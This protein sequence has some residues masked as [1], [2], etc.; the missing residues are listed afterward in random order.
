M[1]RATSFLGIVLA[2]LMTSAWMGCEPGR[3]STE[4]GSIGGTILGMD[5]G[6]IVVLRSFDKGNLVN[7][8]Q[9]ALDSAGHFIL[10]PESPLPRGYH[11]LLVGRKYPL[12]LITDASEGVTV[13]ATVNGTGNYL[14]QADIMGSP[15]SKVIQDYYD[16]T[17]PLQARLKDIE[18]MARMAKGEDQVAAKESAKSKMDSLAILSLDFAQAHKNTLAALCALEGLDAVEHK[19]LFQET[20]TALEGQY[21]ESFYFKKIK[22]SFNRANLPRTLDLPN[23][24]AKKRTGK[25]SKYGQGDEAPD[26]VMSDPNG[27]ERK[28]S[29]L[30]GKVVLLDFWASWCG[31]CRRE[32]PSVVRAYEKYKDLGFE[33]FSVSLDSDASRWK[34]A[35]EQDQLVWPNHVSDLAGWRNA[36]SREYGISSI[37]HTMLIDRDGKILASHLRG[38]GVESAL[39]GVFGE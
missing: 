27:Q 10:T 24:N 1:K 35:I 3:S 38:Q 28:L 39:R 37:P 2:L 26:I 23:T 4:P 5:V 22:Q 25:N 36:A 11:Q 8:A 19:D 12:V 33:V 31:P 16:A 15:E 21:K 20:L 13:N 18:K 7:V 17:M 6:S 32:N 30:R 14:T 29:D 9:S 34:K